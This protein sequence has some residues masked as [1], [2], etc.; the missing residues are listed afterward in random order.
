[1]MSVGLRYTYQWRLRP[2][3]CPGV[4]HHDSVG[5]RHGLAHAAVGVT[6]HR[7]P[8]RRPDPN[9]TR[10]ARGICGCRLTPVQA[11]LLPVGG[12]SAPTGTLSRHTLRKA[13][14]RVNSDCVLPWTAELEHVPV[15]DVI[16]GEALL[17]EQV[18]EELPEVAGIEGGN[19]P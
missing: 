1:M 3:G 19:D 9:N 12:P 8:A 2:T 14:G 5:R 10:R 17:V 18:A 4:L 15:K 7:N 16:V 13:S 6:P 11:V